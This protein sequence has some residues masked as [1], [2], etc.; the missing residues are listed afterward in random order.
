MPH[1]TP[2]KLGYDLLDATG[3]YDIAI[4]LSTESFKD[5][6]VAS[7]IVRC[8]RLLR[9]IYALADADMRLE[10]VVLLRTLTE[11]AI[12]LAWM[13]TDD[14]EYHLAQWAV[15]DIDARFK[16]HN[17]VKEVAGVEVLTPE[18]QAQ[19]SV[20]REGFVAKCGG[21][22]TREPSLRDQAHTA[23]DVGGYAGLKNLYAL[24]YR[25]DSQHA[26]HATVWATEMLMEDHDSDSLVIYPEVAPG[27]R[28]VDVYASGAIVLGIVLAIGLDALGNEDLHARVVAIHNQLPGL[29]PPPPS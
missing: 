28:Q 9:G 18:T 6:L 27:R 11:Y 14:T 13:L 10:A 26:A 20:Q 7:I 19:L 22:S 17:D 12:K 1:R 25:A 4:V 24:P 3:R 29:A 5:I 8:R 16:L 21:R 23:E 2:R 15:A